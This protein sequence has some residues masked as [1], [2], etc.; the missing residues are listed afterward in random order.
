LL[1]FAISLHLHIYSQD[2][3]PP[4]LSLKKSWLSRLRL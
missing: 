2:L 1:P 4:G 3:K